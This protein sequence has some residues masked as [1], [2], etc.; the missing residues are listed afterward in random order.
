MIKNA[1]EYIIGLRK[2]EILKLENETYSDKPL[3]RISYNPK[4]S[5]IRM[6]TLSSLVDYIKANIDDMSEKMIIHIQSPTI[7]NTTRAN[8]PNKIKLAIKQPCSVSSYSHPHK[9]KRKMNDS[10]MDKNLI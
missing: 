3:Q 9:K 7:P 8:N 2:P 10:I 1:L 6:T 4:A 5:P